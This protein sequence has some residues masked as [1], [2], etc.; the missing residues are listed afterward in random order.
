MY[1]RVINRAKL[2]RGNAGTSIKR[3]GEDEAVFQAS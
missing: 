3:G 2:S 1:P